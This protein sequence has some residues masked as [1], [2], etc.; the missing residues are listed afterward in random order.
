MPWLHDGRGRSRP[1]QGI[2]RS[3]GTR[4][5]RGP[6]GRHAVA[7]G[8]SGVDEL[9]RQRRPGPLP[10]SK[11]QLEQRSQ[12]EPFKDDR[13]PG[14]AASMAGDQPWRCRRCE[15]DS[16]ERGRSGDEPVEDHRDPT[17]DRA[18]DHPDQCRDLEAADRRQH[19]E[20]V[21]RIGSMAGK[22]SG[23]RLDLVRVCG[24]VDP[25]PATRYPV[26]RET[27]HG[28]GDGAGCRRVADTHLAD[29]EQVDA[30]LPERSGDVEPDGDGAQR[31]GAR[32][33]VADRSCRACPAGRARARTSQAVQ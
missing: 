12:A 30:P 15:G 33:R 16:E 27:G 1:R 29:G 23:D 28:R 3:G 31:L 32:H 7:Q 11:V 20:R 2:A 9:D 22:R 5:A 13:V 18:E 24:V 10:Q 19:A 14:L 6:E 4:H 21:G 26:R 25:R 8:H 17:R